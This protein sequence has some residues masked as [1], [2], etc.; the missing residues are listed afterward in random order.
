MEKRRRTPSARQ[1]A[2]MEAK[3]RVPHWTMLPEE[4]RREV[5]ELL[6]R[7]LRNEAVVSEEADDE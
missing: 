3:L 1:L 7:L 5:I 4:C 2:L 6:A